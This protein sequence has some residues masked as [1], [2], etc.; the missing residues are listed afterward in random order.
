MSNHNKIVKLFEGIK[1]KVKDEQDPDRVESKPKKKVYQKPPSNWSAWKVVEFIKDNPEYMD[2]EY[3]EEPILNDGLYMA[4]KYASEIKTKRW[5]KFERVYLFEEKKERVDIFSYSFVERYIFKFFSPS[6]R[7]NE[8]E[9]LI[10]KSLSKFKSKLNLAKKSDQFL[11]NITSNK[12]SE[13]TLKEIKKAALYGKACGLEWMQN[14][15]RD[16]FLSFWELIVSKLAELPVTQADRDTCAHSSGDTSQPFSVT[17]LYHRLVNLND[18]ELSDLFEDTTNEWTDRLTNLFIN[19]I[20][21]STRFD[22]DSELKSFKKCHRIVSRVSEVL[23]N[24]GVFPENLQKALENQ[25]YFW[26]EYVGMCSKQN[27]LVS[28]EMLNKLSS[29]Y[30]EAIKQVVSGESSHNYSSR[31]MHEC[32]KDFFEYLAKSKQRSDKIEEILLSLDS[33]FLAKEYVNAFQ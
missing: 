20:K 7:S 11:F 29:M 10:D 24:L 3:F 31:T 25:P 22:N 32:V 28:E 13:K 23:K 15:A 18:C 2:N 9:I 17:K 14:Q 1:I 4:G 33:L 30:C 21:V 12:V 19:S 16:L 8:L 26:F 6:E 27:K 5:P